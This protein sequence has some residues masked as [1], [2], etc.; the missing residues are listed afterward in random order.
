MR[1]RTS[2]LSERFD[3]IILYPNKTK[4]GEAKLMTLH[5]LRTDSCRV[6]E[7][8]YSVIYY[9]ANLLGKNKCK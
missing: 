6:D 9:D 8:S 5:K 2:A 3:S 4:V 7:N 1:N